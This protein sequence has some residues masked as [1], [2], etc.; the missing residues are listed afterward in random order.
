MSL[1]NSRMGALRSWVLTAVFAAALTGPA[2]AAR[3]DFVV[4]LPNGY[5]I[6]RDKSKSPVIVKR[7]G[8]TVLKGAVDA[9]AVYRSVVTGSIK[10]DDGAKY[11][12]LD[13]STGKLETGLAEDAWKARLKELGVTGSP[14]ISPPVLP[15]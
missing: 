12:V 2:A 5:L 15:E 13:T 10:S 4:V 11:F 14:E 3:S 1:T 7:S 6:Q 8:G 9:Y